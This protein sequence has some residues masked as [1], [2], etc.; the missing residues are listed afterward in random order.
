MDVLHQT[1]GHEEHEPKQRHFCTESLDSAG[2]KNTYYGFIEDIIEVNY[3]RNLQVPVFKCKWARVPN[4]VEVD[5]YGFTIIDLNVAGYKNDPWILTGNVAQVFYITDP[6]NA[7][8]EIV[9]GKQR[10]AGVDNITDPKEYNQS[11][12]VPPFGGPKK[13]KQVEITLR[14]TSGLPY[15]ST[16]VKGMLV[17]GK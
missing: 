16:D 1:E 3:G 13:V 8:K 7:K 15:L 14:R 17:Q 5:N 9:P 6:V 11:D 10:V 4:G 12:D 2:N